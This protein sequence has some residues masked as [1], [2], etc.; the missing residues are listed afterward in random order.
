MINENKS[1]KKNKWM[2]GWMDPQTAT[3][4]DTA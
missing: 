1:G 4:T 3:A 2:D